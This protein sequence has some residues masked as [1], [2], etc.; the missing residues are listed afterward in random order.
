MATLR[1]SAPSRD[2]RSSEGKAVGIWIRVSTEDQARGESP[3]HHEK[4]A[5]MYVESKG[6]NVIRLYDLSGV[7]GKTVMGHPETQ[8]MLEDVRSGRIRG[9]VFSKLARLARNTRELLEFSDYFKL[10]EADLISLQESID[11]SS[12]AGRLFYTL[13]AAMAQWERE[14]IADRV[15]ASVIVRAKLGKPLG[16]APFGYHWK[17]GKLSVNEEEA[18]L[19]RRVFELFREHRRVKRVAAILND[20]GFRSRRGARFSSSSILHI[21]NTPTSKGM[22]RAN[23]TKNIG[24]TKRWVLKPEGEWVWTPAPAIVDEALWEECNRILRERIKGKKPSKSVTNLFAGL[25]VCYC[26]TKMYVPSNMPKY[27]CRGC[28]HKVAVDDLEKAF[29]DRLQTFFL[30]EG[31]V[32]SWL[33]DADDT[34]RTKEELL[35]RLEREQQRVKVESEKLYRLY[36]D[37]GLTT[38]GFKERNQPLAART[39]QLAD[40]VPRLQ[41]EIDFLRIER[42]SAADISS[43]GRDYYA[44]WGGYSFEEKRQMVETVVSQ[45]TLGKEE[46]SFEMNHLLAPPESVAQGAGNPTGAPRAR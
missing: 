3:D 21:L 15:A 25:T 9:L 35:V 1:E 11:T 37:D 40:E 20:G 14:E 28:H 4:R 5:R 19:A 22:H 32:A 24:G 10:H 13:I 38:A 2:P 30:D 36:Q 43:R 27:Y 6:W 8:A 34:L 12:P 44:G 18:P 39:E 17:D 23:Y 16:T 33:A 7:S 26:G 41:A 31:E 42:Y 45:I 46:I 29:V